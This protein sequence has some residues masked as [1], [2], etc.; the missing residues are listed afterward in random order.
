[1]EDDY[2]AEIQKFFQIVDNNLEHLAVDIDRDA[3]F[4][5]AGVEYLVPLFKEAT[6]LP[7]VM[8]EALTGN[9]ELLSAEELHARA[10]EIVEPWFLREQKRAGERFG[11]L[12]GTGRAA[13]DIREILPAAHDGRV[14]ALFTA[15]GE[16]IWGMYDPETRTIQ[17]QEE[18]TA[19]QNG[20]EDLLDRAAVQTFLH[21]GKVFAVEQ[22]EVPQGYAAAAVFRY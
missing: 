8:D 1:M 18:Q 4:V 3:P 14:D 19:Q 5:L 12:Q 2:K 13:W 16:R 22:Q 21:G 7:H 20:S 6:R 11:E 15:R 10:W 17:F 9:P